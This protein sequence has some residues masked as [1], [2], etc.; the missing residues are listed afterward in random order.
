MS[1]QSQTFIEQ[2]REVEPRDS[3]FHPF[4]LNALVD[5][6][7]G[8][9][10]S[11]VVIPAIFEFMENNSD[12]DLGVPGALV[13]FLEKQP[14]YKSS[15]VESVRR[16]PTYYTVWMVNRM[17]NNLPDGDEWRSYLDLLRSTLIHPLIDEADLEPVR[18]Y[19]EHQ[20]KRL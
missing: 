9:S 6:L 10:D 13:F 1:P 12:A 4:Q 17:M 16:L 7:Q 8:A 20:Q 18:G 15:L 3:S 19:I 11:Q 14:D 5:A 2:L